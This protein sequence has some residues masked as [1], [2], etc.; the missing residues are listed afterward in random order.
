MNKKWAICSDESRGQLFL[1]FFLFF[2]FAC[3]RTT[4]SD[5]KMKTVCR[6]HKILFYFLLFFKTFHMHIF[7][8]AKYQHTVH[9]LSTNYHTHR[10][11]PEF[12]FFVE[13]F[14]CNKRF[15]DR[16]FGFLYIPEPPGLY[17]YYVEH[18]MLNIVCVGHILFANTP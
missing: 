14:V 6:S 2:I 16:L 10:T 17:V 3:R 7:F 11:T 9:R 8:L 5:M 1:F 13:Q 15:E 4:N 12:D 18:G